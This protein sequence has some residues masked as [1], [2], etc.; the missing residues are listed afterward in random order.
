MS[1][2]WTRWKV[3]RKKSA[4]S[5]TLKASPRVK[6]N[7]VQR[8]RAISPWAVCFP[9]ESARLRAAAREYPYST[10][11]AFAV[12][13]HRSKFRLGY[14]RTDDRSMQSQ[15]SRGTKR[16]TIYW[17]ACISANSLAHFV[18]LLNEGTPHF[19]SSSSSL[20]LP[21]ILITRKQFVET[22]KRMK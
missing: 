8:C 15:E 22:V 18:R 11:H 5:F 13:H 14:S 3:S 10:V 16:L 17:S 1:E 12:P 2:R 6:F 7:T 20:A 19:V 4:I 9:S 21:N